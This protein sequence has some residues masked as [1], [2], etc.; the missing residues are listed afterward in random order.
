MKLLTGYWNNMII[1]KIF[2]NR[3]CV[4]LCCLIIIAPKL[5]AQFQTTTF[6][7]RKQLWLDRDGAK[8]SGDFDTRVHFGRPYLFAWLEKNIYISSGHPTLGIFHDQ[9]IGLYDKRGKA[10]S[11]AGLHLSRIFYQYEHILKDPSYPY[12]DDWQH[13]KDLLSFDARDDS[14]LNTRN[15]SKATQPQR[16]VTSFL[17]TLDYDRNA[18]VLWP[19]GSFDDIHFTS[20]FSGNQYVPGNRYNTYELSRDWLFNALDTWAKI[21]SNELDGNY[22]GLA[23]HSLLLLYDFADR[24]LE[25]LDRSRDEDGIEMKKR[26]R[27]V[28][29]LLLLDQIMDFSANH[30]GG[31]FGRIYRY[32]ITHALVRALYY[33]Y[34]GVD[35]GDS[36]DDGDAYVSSYRLPAYIEDL[37]ILWD[38]PSSYWH[39]HQENNLV[40]SDA[41][42]GKW[43]YVTKYFNLGGAGPNGAGW[44]LAIY[45][46]DTN[47]VR[48]GQPFRLWIDGSPSSADPDESLNEYTTTGSGNMYQFQNTAFFKFW[49]DPHVHVCLDGNRFDEGHDQL[50]PASQ[51]ANDF[52]IN[53]GWNFFRESNVAI[54][55]RLDSGRIGAMEVVIIDPNVSAAHCYPTFEDFK[56]AVRNNCELTKYYFVTSRGNMI[57]PGNNG[58]TVN[59][60]PIWQFPFKRM[61]TIDNQGRKLI[62]WDNN[63]MTITENNKRIV[64]DFNNWEFDDSD[65]NGDYIAPAPPQSVSVLPDGLP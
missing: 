61:E 43:T 4:I 20:T 42:Y 63:I 12:P 41:N 26:A 13:I 39:I 58:G 8:L 23:L 21:G 25:R 19:S 37:G 51:Y 32:N 57:E 16:T 5:T 14:H 47:A 62:A 56:N 49:D 22:T 1:F 10:G 48:P 44:Q 45:S 15:W 11:R 30:H 36:M 35:K 50:H 65:Q 3:I 54:A 17:H 9:L 64:Y 6:A 7:Q 46:E 24:P 33:P 52:N 2:L 60:Q 28:L 31:A 27:M 38:E 59:G 18:T 29:D 53:Q 55:L 40:G 34:F